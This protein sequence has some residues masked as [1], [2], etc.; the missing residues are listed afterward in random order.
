M[1]KGCKFKTW[2]KTQLLP[3]DWTSVLTEK[4]YISAVEGNLAVV[5]YFSYAVNQ[6]RLTGSTVYN[7]TGVLSVQLNFM[8]EFSCTVCTQ[9]S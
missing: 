3:L 7:Q 8:E 6:F 4:L 1:Q 2:L 5:V 9:H